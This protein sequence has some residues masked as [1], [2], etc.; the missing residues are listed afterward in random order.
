[1]LN[2]T[3]NA[4]FLDDQSMPED[5]IYLWAYHIKIINKYEGEIVIK[6]RVF[7][8]VDCLGQRQVIEG[9]GV[10]NT[11]PTIKSK[12]TFEYA[13]GVLLNQ[14]SGFFHGYYVVKHK[15]G[16]QTIENIPSFSLDSKY[17]QMPTA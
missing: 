12:E 4:V 15:D 10:A 2:I 17:A 1:M 16:A 9:I 8:V 3:I 14:P 6:K 13:S 7:E 11:E 5:D